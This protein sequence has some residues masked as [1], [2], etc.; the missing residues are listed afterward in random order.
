[1]DFFLEAEMIEKNPDKYGKLQGPLF[2]IVVQKP[3]EFVITGVEVFEIEILYFI[4]G[5]IWALISTKLL[6]SDMMSGT[7]MNQ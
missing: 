7:K 3:D 6:T 5:S 4:Q 2:T 1:M